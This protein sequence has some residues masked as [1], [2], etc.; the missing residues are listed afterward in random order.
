ML[1]KH[2]E[3]CEPCNFTSKEWKDLL[4]QPDALFDQPNGADEDDE[5][6]EEDDDDDED[7]EDEGEGGE[8]AAAR[9]ARRARSGA[10]D[11]SALVVVPLRFLGQ[12]IRAVAA[13]RR[14]HVRCIARRVKIAMVHGE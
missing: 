10:R 13:P 12:R 11:D 2:D 3:N 6:E 14:L 4:K 8:A 5:E 7:D 9:A 1:L